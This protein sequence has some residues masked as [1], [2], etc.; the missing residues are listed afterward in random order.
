MVGVQVLDNSSRTACTDVA[1]T[2]AEP[3]TIKVIDDLS[4]KLAGGE[5]ELAEA[6]KKR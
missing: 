4:I 3:V 6:I 2:S 1:G 5:K